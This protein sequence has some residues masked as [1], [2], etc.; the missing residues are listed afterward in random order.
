MPGQSPELWEKA[1][2]ATGI[3][4]TWI[5]G[6]F[7]LS[8][9]YSSLAVTDTKLAERIVATNKVLDELKKQQHEDM[10]KV[11][12]MF[13]DDKGNP[14]LISW[15]AH[16]HTCS[17]RQENV[18]AEFKHLSTRMDDLKNCVLGLRKE[19]KKHTEEKKDAA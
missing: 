6:W 1:L 15:T 13:T 16:E 19:L 8:K 14:R 9:V 7:G 18:N 12:K 17:L 3:V 4:L 5:T 2:W 11:I 10:E